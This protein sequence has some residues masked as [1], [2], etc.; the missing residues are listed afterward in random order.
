MLGW[1]LG[2]DVRQTP[3]PFR[4]P[5]NNGLEGHRGG[6]WGVFAIFSQESYNYRFR[7]II[8]SPPTQPDS[9]EA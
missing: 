9:V 3:T 5:I 1:V 7:M 8:L 6:C 2:G 4:L